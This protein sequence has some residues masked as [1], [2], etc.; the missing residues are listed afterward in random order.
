MREIVD[1][2]TAQIG[3]SIGYGAQ[4][5]ISLDRPHPARPKRPLSHVILNLNGTYTINRG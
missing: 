5:A 1:W 2:W 3:G 4:T